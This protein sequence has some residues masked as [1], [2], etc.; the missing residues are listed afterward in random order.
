[1]KELKKQ[2][3]IFPILATVIAVF[4]LTGCDKETIKDQWLDY[5]KNFDD[6]KGHLKQTKTYSSE[7]VIKWMDMQLRLIRTNATPLG[8]LVPGRFFGYCGIALYESVVPGMPDYKSLAGQLIAMPDMPATGHGLAYHWPTCANAA[9]AAMNRNFFPTT[10]AAN[11]ASLDS[12]ENALNA[13]YALQTT[14]EIFQRSVAYGKAVAQLII[15]WANTDGTLDVNP[16]YTPPPGP[17]NWVPTPPAFAAAAAPYWGNHRLFVS[18]SLNGSTP[19]PPPAYSTLPSSPYLKMVREVYE[20]SQHLTPAQIATGLYYRD[21][22]GYGGGHY[23]SILMGVLIQERAM[24]DVT[25]IAY[26]KAGIAC[27]EAGIGCWQVKYLYNVERPITYIAGVMNRPGWAPLFA[28]PNFPEYTSGHATVGG[29]FTTVMASL[30]GNN[31]HFTNHTYDYLGMAP[32]SFNSFKELA[33][34]ISISRVYAG[35]HYRISCE[36]G[37]TSGEKIGKNINEKLKFKK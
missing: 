2:L 12:L 34:D 33:N 3:T 19:L 24:L 5:K 30:F 28:T 22:P 15:N 17:G 26:A 21:N 18:G 20:L 8:G 7:G 35:I 10:S 14:Q 37:Q 31:Y 29:S 6:S 27:V 1:M 25:A 11:K 13:T 16:P 36:R 4:L 9:L 32:R 23:L